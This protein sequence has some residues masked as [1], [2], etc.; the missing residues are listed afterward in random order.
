M[1][2]DSLATDVDMPGE[3]LGWLATD[4]LMVGIIFI[5]SYGDANLHRPVIVLNPRRD[6]GFRIPAEAFAPFPIKIDDL[7]T[8]TDCDLVIRMRLGSNFYFDGIATPKS[9]VVVASS[10]V[11]RL[12]SGQFITANRKVDTVAQPPG[13][14]CRSER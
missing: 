3:T 14:E 9:G 8:R 10:G 4:Y 5:L 13:F 1:F 7:S 11:D 12:F 6:F 2:A